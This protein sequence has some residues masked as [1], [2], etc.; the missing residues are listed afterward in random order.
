MTLNSNENYSA[1]I[2]I[3]LKPP[4]QQKKEPTPPQSTTRVQHKMEQYNIARQQKLQKLRE[5]YEQKERE[6]MTPCTK[7]L[8]KKLKSPNKNKKIESSNSLY[9]NTNFYNESIPE[10]EFDINYS[11]SPNTYS[12][13]KKAYPTNK[14][15]LLKNSEYSGRKNQKTQEYWDDEGSLL[16]TNRPSP[17]QADALQDEEEFY[18]DLPS[19]PKRVEP[20]GKYP[21]LAERALITEKNRTPESSFI[22]SPKSNSPNTPKTNSSYSPKSNSTFSP[23]SNSSSPKSTTTSFKEFEE[24]QQR[25]LDQREKQRKKAEKKLLEDANRSYTLPRSQQIYKSLKQRG[26]D[27]IRQKKKEKDDEEEYTF[28]PD[29]SISK[30][31]LKD[32]PPGSAS[33]SSEIDSSSPQKKDN[34]SKNTN[35]RKIERE[36]AFRIENVEA[37][38]IAREVQLRSAQIEEEV[39]KMVDYTFTPQKFSKYNLN[40]KSP[41]PGHLNKYVENADKQMTRARNSGQKIREEENTKLREND[42]FSHKIST[43]PSSTKKLMNIVSEMKKEEDDERYNEKKNSLYERSLGTMRRRA[44]GRHFSS[45]NSPQKEANDYEYYDEE[46][47]KDNA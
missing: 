13:R 41:S 29:T 27:P 15:N 5:E 37:Q 10:N 46:E 34:E 40:S 26:D 25:L 16:N 23:K 24:R 43:P 11:N 17:S 18:I 12:S 35:N 38:F 7:P 3:R 47:D 42:R 31:R 28:I 14:S 1:Q 9:Y 39:S 20:K 44:K 8:Q 22:N 21:S 36:R 2:N 33:K 45:L 30:K 32:L 19:S 4:P 6:S